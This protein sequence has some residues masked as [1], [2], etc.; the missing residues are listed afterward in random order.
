MLAHPGFYPHLAHRRIGAGV[1][2]FYSEDNPLYWFRL[3]QRAWY[4]MLIAAG[5]A[6]PGPAASPS[7]TRR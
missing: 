6:A 5:S 1:M 3:A 4:E 7:R 2:A